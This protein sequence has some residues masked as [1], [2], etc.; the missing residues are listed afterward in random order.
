[1]IVV[2]T[3]PHEVTSRL[4]GIRE[5]PGKRDHPLIMAALKLT[6]DG[7]WSNW[8]DHD[9]VPWCSALPNLVC[10]LL[11]LP[12]SGSLRARSWLEVGEAVDLADAEVGSDLVVLWRGE[13]PQPGPDVIEAPGHVGWFSGTEDGHVHILGG[14]QSNRVNVR[15]YPTD[16]VLGVRRIT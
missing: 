6:H 11:G 3:T 8:P 15:S 16:R 12:R 9:E 2:H 5:L 4:I 7:K 1:M 10:M 14:N 13:P